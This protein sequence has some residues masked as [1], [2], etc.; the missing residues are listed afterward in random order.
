MYVVSYKELIVW[1]KSITLA[2]EVYQST[3]RLTKSELYG[4]I[5]QMRMAAVSIP[6][7]VA[8]G[9]KRRG[10]SEYIHFLTISDGSAAEL[11]TQIIIVKEIYPEIDLFRAES[12]LSEV[13][14]MLITMIQKLEAKKRKE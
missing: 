1:Q 14:R 3:E 4:L 10:L 12:L 6:S 9:Y 2:K 11:E 13:Q 7:N 8:E 5:S